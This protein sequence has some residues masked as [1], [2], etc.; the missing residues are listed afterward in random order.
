MKKNKFGKSVLFAVN[1]IAYGISK[2]RNIKIQIII[3]LFVILISILLKIPQTD[4]III[5]LVSFLVIILELVNTGIDK[6]IDK[7]S[8]GFDKDY[9]KIKDIMAGVVLLAVILSVIVGFLI[10]FNPIISVITCD[11]YP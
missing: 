2:E 7:L 6:L 10:L 8:P 11:C 3:G 5:L 1:G 9:G 4:F